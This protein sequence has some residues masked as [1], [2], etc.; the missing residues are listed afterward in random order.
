M[1]ISDLIKTLEYIKN[2]NGDLQVV[3]SVDERG[4]VQTYSDDKIFI[5]ENNLGPGQ[6]EV[7]IQNFPY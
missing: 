6:W 4:E 1:K 2:N 5:S 3:L 7:S